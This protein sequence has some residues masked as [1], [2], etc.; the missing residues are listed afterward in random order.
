[1]FDLCQVVCGSKCLARRE[2]ARDHVDL[3]L[4]SRYWPPVYVSDCA[5]QVALC[6][7]MQY[8]EQATQMWGRNQGCFCDPFEDPEVGFKHAVKWVFQLFLMTS[9]QFESDLCSFVSQIV[10]CAELQDQ[11]YSTDLSSGAENQQVHPITKSL[12]RWLVHPPGQTQEPPSPKH[13][14][15]HLCRDLEPY[16]SLLNE[17]RKDKKEQT[18]PP[19]QADSSE[20]AEL[21]A[22]EWS[23]Q[24]QPVVF[25]NTAHYYL[26]NRL[27]DFITSRDIVNQQISEV[28]QAC[29]PGEVVIRD[30]LYRLGVAK[31][32]TEKDEEVS[33]TPQTQAAEAEALDPVELHE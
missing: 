17:S 28:L 10:S 31:I 12:S 27:V 11:P 26:Y 2:T 3:L 22:S 33:E 4:S 5:H 23:A 30:T 15:M 9:N 8:P 24:E 1:M 29:Q 13:H 14:S 18:A 19:D 16:I 25:N 7:D 32:D 6:A 20:T 21:S